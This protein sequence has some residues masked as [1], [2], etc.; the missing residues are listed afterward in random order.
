M[1]I[2]E[3]SVANLEL[4]AEAIR[5]GALV[6]MPTE[7]VYGVAANAM[8]SDAVRRTFA[9]KQRPA[10]NPLI[11]HVAHLR[12]VGELVASF[13]Q[14]AQL[15]AEAFWPGPLTLVLPKASSVSPLVTGGLDTVAVRVPDHPVAL[16]LIDLAGVPISAP[17]ANLFMGLSPT[18][19][20]HIDPAL[21]DLLA[22]VLDGG[23]CEVGLESTVIDVS[24]D[25]PRLLRPGGITRS[26]V[27]EVLRC[28]LGA[29]VQ[30]E[31]KAPGLYRRHYAPRTPLRLVEELPT[32]ASG[33]TFSPAVAGQIQLPLNP[34]AYAISLYAALHRLDAEGHSEILVQ[35]PPKGAEWE[36]VWDR[37]QRAI[38]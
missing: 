18:V 32:G 38:G 11:V 36:A 4:A 24:A 34:R 25:E 3:P 16:R 33:I 31:R 37:L 5:A 17:S 10:D 26:Q 19:A 12:Q 2:L 27:E 13:P 30:G 15:L 20:E 9:A 28:S 7:T 21:G 23:P 6:G 22:M 14:Q 35:A 8:D 29:P 1:R